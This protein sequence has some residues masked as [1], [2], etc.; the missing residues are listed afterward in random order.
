M[1]GKNWPHVE[2]GAENSHGSDGYEEN[3]YAIAR[4]P[5]PGWARSS[6][7]N[8]VP[9]I[10]F[11]QVPVNS[12][13]FVE[14]SFY[15]GQNM[16]SMGSDRT[17]MHPRRCNEAVHRRTG[18]RPAKVNAHPVSQPSRLRRPVAGSLTMIMKTAVSMCIIVGSN[19]G[20][21]TRRA[22]PGCCFHLYFVK[23]I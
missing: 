12:A 1:P 19:I 22:A 9:R 3:I 21:D 4:T 11:A 5:S 16:H 8:R 13:K 6:Q 20:A 14:E 18:T 17:K 23:S 10:D 7:A 2:R 15:R